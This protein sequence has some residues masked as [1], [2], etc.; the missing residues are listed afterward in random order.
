M[1]VEFHYY[2]TYLTA[3]RAGYNPNEART[4][5]HACQMVDDNTIRHRIDT[6]SHSY[7][8]YI[9]Q[10]VN[11]LKPARE[12]F[13]IYF[14]F[15]FI[16]GDSEKADFRQDGMSSLLNT[17]PNSSNARTIMEQ[18][19]TENDPY[20]TGIACHAFADTW[21]H[22]NFIGYYS[23]FNAMRGSFESLAPNIGHAD[24][25]QYPDKPGL[26]WQD[27]RLMNQTVKNSERFLDA[28]EALFRFLY[29]RQS[30]KG[31]EADF[32]VSVLRNDLSKIISSSK[33]DNKNSAVRISM[34]RSLATQSSYGGEPLPRYHKDA[35][36][37]AA[38]SSHL[39]PKWKDPR[40]Y[41]DTDWY[42][43]Q[44]KIKFYQDQIS[45]PI[46]QRRVFCKMNLASL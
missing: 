34:Y 33:P 7:R 38:V 46:L 25:G 36:F 40:N 44:E 42:R 29:A 5:A 18:T 45:W 31:T 22:Q 1:D 19:L 2:M 30:S 12:L 37:K 21:A 39:L 13:R 41:Q 6:G 14:Q 8:N 3:V 9:S 16:P 23:H 27:V 10:T 26:N 15:H 35:W 24:A 4:I 20:L 43:F 17:T 32:E 28:A 11:I